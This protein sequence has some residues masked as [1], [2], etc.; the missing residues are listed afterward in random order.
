[1][2][3]FYIVDLSLPSDEMV[4]GL[5]NNDNDLELRMDKVNLG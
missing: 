1:M 5:I 4:L 2:A 3:G